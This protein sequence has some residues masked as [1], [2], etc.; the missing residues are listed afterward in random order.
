MFALLLR[1]DAE[2]NDLVMDDSRRE[3]VVRAL[4]SLSLGG[5]LAHGFAVGLV[6]ELAPPLGDAGLAEW[7]HG[8][9]LLWMAPC[10]VAAFVGGLALCLPSFY[11][12]TQLA[13]VEASPGL[14]VAQGLRALARTGVILLGAEPFFVAV[15]FG[16]ILGWLSASAVTWVGLAMPFL[17]GVLGVTS[18]YKSF[19]ALLD[20]VDIT[21]QRK[22]DF[23]LHVAFA[24]ACLYLVVAPVALWR[25]GQLLGRVF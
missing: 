23:V 3:A 7:L 1:D 14:V 16:S 6:A 22:G 11:F 25:V 8:H 20:R 9:P 5:L 17:V 2:L 21:H 19:R 13:G 15:V 12:F 18:V 4:V 10:L 24:W